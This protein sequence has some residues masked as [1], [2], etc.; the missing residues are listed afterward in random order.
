MEP[1]RKWQVFP[2]TPTFS[3][4]QPAM[5]NWKTHI[6]LAAKCATFRNVVVQTRIIT[7]GMITD[8]SPDHSIRIGPKPHDRQQLEDK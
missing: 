2:R 8:K 7:Y 5:E 4:L 1:D 3:G 6:R